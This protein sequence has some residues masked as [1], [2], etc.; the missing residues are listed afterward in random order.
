MACLF[1]STGQGWQSMDVYGAVVL[2]KETDT[3][4]LSLDMLYYEPWQERGQAVLLWRHYLYFDFHKNYKKLSDRFHCF[5]S[6]DCLYGFLFID[7]QDA[8]S[9][10]T[11]VV[12]KASKECVRA[13]GGFKAFFGFSSSGSNLSNN[14]KA[15]ANKPKKLTVDDM[16]DPTNFEHLI[17]IGFNPMTGA[18]EPHNVPPEWADFFEKAGLSSA[19]L[20]D[21]KTATYVAHFVQD[22]VIEPRPRDN[23]GQSEESKPAPQLHQMKTAPPPP[24]PPPVEEQTQSESTLPAVPSDRANLMDSIRRSSVS[25]LKPVPKEDS[26]QSQ[27]VSS[28][29]PAGSDLMA[30]MLAKALAERNQKVANGTLSSSFNKY[31]RLGRR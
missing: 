8:E 14:K 30:S 1:K 13:R 17:H 29:Q 3:N 21:K 9:F 16:S 24:P 27:P 31:C 28:S 20:Q 12:K 7:E 22:N 23:N 18:F 2:V 5:E 15:Q 11:A 26:N 4:L 19:D 25:V 10:Y 6:D